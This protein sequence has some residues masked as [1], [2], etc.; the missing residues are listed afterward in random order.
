VFSSAMFTRDKVQERAGNT[1]DLRRCFETMRRDLHSAIVPPDDSGLTFGISAE[2]TGSTG[3][4]GDI[5]QFASVVGEPLLLA[6][7]ANE[8]VLIQYALAEDP[9]TGDPTLWRY[10]TAYP[11]PDAT[12]SGSSATGM[13]DD[14]RAVPLLRNVTGA[15][16]LFYSPAQQTW[17]N[18]WEGETGLPTA[19][20]VDLAIGEQSPQA[21]AKL[22]SWVFALSAAA[23]TTETEG[24]AGAETSGTGASQ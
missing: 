21:Q 10:E 3:T 1:G 19:I 24:E 14:T 16:Y 22:Q 20:R 4:G 17:V 9:R 15:T 7:P 13:S 6:R 23:T 2:G 5:L 18:T 12:S 11:V 8:T